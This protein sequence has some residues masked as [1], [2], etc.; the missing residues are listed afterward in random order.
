[1]S[2]TYT[3][4]N[5]RHNHYSKLEFYDSFRIER[6]PPGSP[7]KFITH[8]ICESDQ[9]K[10]RPLYGRQRIRENAFK[11]KPR[12]VFLTE[13][14]KDAESLLELGLVATTNA[15]GSQG[16]HKTDITPLWGREVVIVEDNDEAGM[17]RSC[18]LYWLLKEHP[19]TVIKR[20]RFKGKTKGYDISDYLEEHSGEEFLALADAADEW[21]PNEEELPHVL[22]CQSKI[23]GNKSN[24]RKEQ[25]QGDVRN[26]FE[27]FS[28]KFHER[29]LVL[30]E[31]LVQNR[32]MVQCCCH[33]D[34]NPSLS[35]D[36]CDDERFLFYCFGCGARGTDVVEEL[37]FSPSSLFPQKQNFAVEDEWTEFPLDELP[38]VLSEFVR[39]TATT[40]ACAEINVINP[41]FSVL[42]GAIGNSRRLRLSSKWTEPSII[43]TA[44]LAH[45]GEKKSPPLD[46]CTELI[47]KREGKRIKA[48]KEL[49][50]IYREN[51]A[52]KSDVQE[53]EKPC[54]SLVGDTTTERLAE[55]LDENSRGLLLVRDELD[56]WFKSFNE[57]KRSSSDRDRW[58]EFWRG[59]H[60]QVDRKLNSFQL[61]IPHASVSVTGTMQP[62]IFQKSMSHDNFHSG[63]G[64]RLLLAYP[65]RKRR[66]INDMGNVAKGKFEELVEALLELELSDHN[67][68]VE[69]NLSKAAYQRFMLIC[70]EIADINVTCPS[71][72]AS[73]WSKVEAYVARFSLLLALVENVEATSVDVSHVERGRSIAFWYGRE[74]V[75]VYSGLRKKEAKQSGDKIL[76]DVRS[77][78]SSV[79]DLSRRYGIKGDTVREWVR[80][81]VDEGVLSWENEKQTRIKV[82]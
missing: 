16:V 73:I 71:W 25:I 28:K 38:L 15:H 7:H 80:P 74:M 29:G 60:M 19:D 47:R 5:Q 69:V 42:S 77:G 58:L 57:Y 61:S 26:R 43:W 44:T 50:S 21:I 64:G 81:L 23:F 8:W 13:G 51:N 68:P 4:Q 65:P 62:E 3:Y 36:I 12:P 20:I 22:A 72:Q 48:Y 17:K 59:Q 46:E 11:E 45:S 66:R 14:E 49:L 82:A 56:G 41:M 34:L 35:F 78:T 9:D 6:L 1:M 52:K 75:R 53:P 40:I 30:K 54:R 18:A 10:I 76:N 24:I 27:A 37:G 33:P 67:T 55:L 39:E 70:D 32:Y 63:L 31:R 2:K 79:R